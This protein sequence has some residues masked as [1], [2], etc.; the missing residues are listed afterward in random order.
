M[1]RSAAK[2]YQNQPS[3]SKVMGRSVDYCPILSGDLEKVP[4]QMLFSQPRST[5]LLNFM[6]KFKKILTNKQVVAAPVEEC[7]SRTSLFDCRWMKL[8]VD[9]HKSQGFCCC[10]C[11]LL[12]AFI[13]VVVTDVAQF[14][15]Q[16][17]HLDLLPQCHFFFGSTS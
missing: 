14:E 5:S 6:S 8:S 3:G 16:F 10:C 7:L 2:N 17:L 4:N 12:E 9:K 15:V 11:K 13:V 1:R